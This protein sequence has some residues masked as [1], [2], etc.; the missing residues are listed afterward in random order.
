MNIKVL[1]ICLKITTTILILLYASACSLDSDDTTIPMA[2]FTVTG[3]IVEDNEDNTPLSGVRVDLGFPYLNA[4]GD[5][6]I[7]YVDNLT[8]EAKGTFSLNITEYPQP[9]KFKLKVED[10]NEPKRFDTTI[11]A[12]DFI[13]PSFSGGKTTKDMGMIKVNMKITEGPNNPEGTKP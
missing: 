12:V 13:N 1:S 3:T 6:L 11:R 5:T 2:T 7:Y 9:Q 4:E 10:T 8:T